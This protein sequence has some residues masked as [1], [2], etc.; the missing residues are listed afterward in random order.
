MKEAV[1]GL[2]QC[3]ECGS[4]KLIPV[5]V[6]EETNFFCENCV[7][8]WH[9]ERDRVNVVDPQTCPG[10]QLGVRACFERWETSS[11]RPNG[12]VLDDETSSGLASRG[13]VAGTGREEDMDWGD[14]ESELHSSTREAGVGYLPLWASEERRLRLASSELRPGEK[15]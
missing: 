12:R 14:I 1:F 8:C 10:C 2:K 11:K 9:L 4:K 3:P 15:A 7:L 6:E 13:P 5:S